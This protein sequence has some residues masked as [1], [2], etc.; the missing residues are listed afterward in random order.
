MPKPYDATLKE[1]IEAYPADWL[2]AVGVPVTG[3]I[4]VL[5]PEL[6]TSR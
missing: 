4:E 1:L 6:S 3:P 5:S 2:A